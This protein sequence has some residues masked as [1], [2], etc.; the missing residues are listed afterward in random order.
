MKC[1][2]SP[3]AVPVEWLLHNWHDA[4]CLPGCWFFRIT[5]KETP[6]LRYIFAIE[7]CF[8]TRANREDDLGWKAHE[9]PCGFAGKS[10][11]PTLGEAQK[12][13]VCSASVTG[14]MGKECDRD[15]RENSLAWTR[16][17]A[18]LLFL[19]P[20]TKLSLFLTKCLFFLSLSP[21][22]TYDLPASAELLWFQLL[23]LSWFETWVL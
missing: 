7:N 1:Q 22:L 21:A 19:T 9:T 8:K 20:S 11:K 16:V 3:D 14:K 17:S 23:P 12:S 2:C 18:Q 5:C 6:L 4:T 10:L 15:S 13:N